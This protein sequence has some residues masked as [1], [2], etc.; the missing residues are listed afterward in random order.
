MANPLSPA[1]R[2]KALRRDLARS[3]AKSARLCAARAALPPGSSR[4]RV[5][6]ANARWAR[7]AEER[8]RLLRAVELAEAQL[9]V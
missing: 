8:D 5:T 9:S 3:E 1:A 7:A 4:A 2:L 6:T